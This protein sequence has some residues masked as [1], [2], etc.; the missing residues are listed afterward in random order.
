MKKSQ[1]SKD[2]GK[3]AILQAR[4]R[5]LEEKGDWVEELRVVEDGLADE[6]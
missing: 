2:F 1:K 3:I 5:E 6:K 4:N